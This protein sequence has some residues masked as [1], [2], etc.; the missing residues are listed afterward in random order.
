MGGLPTRVSAIYFAVKT[1]G[2]DAI[3]LMRATKLRLLSAGEDAAEQTSA[4]GAARPLTGAGSPDMRPTLNRLS[5]VSSTPWGAALGAV[6]QLGAL[7][8]FTRPRACADVT[9]F[10]PRWE[11]FLEVLFCWWS[12][13]LAGPASGP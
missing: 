9:A 10:L 2:D 3:R 1:R 7:F 4:N 13:P 5:R 8:D 6:E 11:K 12:A